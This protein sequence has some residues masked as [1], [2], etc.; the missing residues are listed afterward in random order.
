MIQSSLRVI[1]ATVRA[2]AVF[3]LAASFLFAASV[4]SSAQVLKRGLQGAGLGAI[5]GGIANGG[6]GAGKGA[7]AGG[8]AGAII[9]GIENSEARRGP[10]P[11]PPPRYVGPPPPRRAAPPPR[12]YATNPVV[13]DIQQSL[14]NM[15]YNPGPVDGRS[16]SQTR[17]AIGAYQSDY[18]LLVD[19]RA[20]PQLLQHM[21][22]HGG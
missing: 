5:I 19:G 20:T 15:G 6:K 11:P 4:D 1:P 14:F 17:R 12:R 18:N 8:V 10:P 7:I 3:G 2:F 21:R 16:G 22:K 9:G 13:R